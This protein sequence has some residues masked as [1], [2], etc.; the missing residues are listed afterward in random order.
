MIALRQHTMRQ[1]SHAISAMQHGVLALEM[2]KAR[3]RAGHR[4]YEV[5]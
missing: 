5:N 2:Q 4:L 1:R 3:H